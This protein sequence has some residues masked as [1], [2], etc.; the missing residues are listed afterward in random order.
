MPGSSGAFARLPADWERR[1]DSALV[2]IPA[3]PMVDESALVH[4]LK[5]EIA[6][7]DPVQVT[8]TTKSVKKLS[9][10]IPN[11]RCTAKANYMIVYKL[12]REA[13]W[14]RG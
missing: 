10:C 5:H 3:R 14:P 4:V 8:K 1:G 7:V 9:S 13:R 6:V 11:L 2:P 12:I